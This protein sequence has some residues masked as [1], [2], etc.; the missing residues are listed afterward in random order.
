LKRFCGEPWQP[1]EFTQGLL[2]CYL[3][4]NE[5]T[6]LAAKQ[7]ISAIRSINFGRLEI[8]TIAALAAACS[9]LDK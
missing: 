2:S 6:L 7:N 5:N 1:G 8:H 9:C 4:S 3:L